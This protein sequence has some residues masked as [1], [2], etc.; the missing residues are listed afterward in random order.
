MLRLFV[1]G[2]RLL[3]GQ[4]SNVHAELKEFNEELNQPFKFHCVNQTRAPGLNLRFVSP[5]EVKIVAVIS[6]IVYNNIFSWSNS[7]MVQL[8]VS[9]DVASVLE[10]F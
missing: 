2:G 4:V 6:S 8:E 10:L 9:E 5:A 1:S 7:S 3:P